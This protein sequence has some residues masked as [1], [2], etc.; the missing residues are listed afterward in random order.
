[1]RQMLRRMVKDND[2]VGKLA[3]IR[4]ALGLKQYF[5]SRYLLGFYFA[6]VGV[7]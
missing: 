2:A 1:M 5:Q 6:L 4:L 7:Y 3:R